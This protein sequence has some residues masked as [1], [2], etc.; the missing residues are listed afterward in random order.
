MYTRFNKIISILLNMI[1]ILLGLMI[2]YIVC[3]L[4]IQKK[5]RYHGPNSKIIKN[6]IYK[7]GGKYYKFIPKVCICPIFYNCVQ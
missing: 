3:Q 1:D 5:I 2:G 4:Y 6:K 7:F